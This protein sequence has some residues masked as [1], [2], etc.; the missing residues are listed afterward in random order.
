MSMIMPLLTICQQVTK[1]H[2]FRVDGVIQDTTRVNTSGRGGDLPFRAEWFN[3]RISI[4]EDRSLL[5]LLIQD[6]FF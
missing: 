1:S 6:G 5:L 2:G 3:K 4:R